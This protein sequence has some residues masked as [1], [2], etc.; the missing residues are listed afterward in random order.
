M[1]RAR[2]SVANGVGGTSRILQSGWNAVKC[3]GTSL[4]RCSTAHRV[5]ASISSS[6]SFS[7]G[8][9]SV[10]TSSQTF[11]SWARYLR[12]S[13]TGRGGRRT[14]PGRTAP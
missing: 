11:V 13:S 12:V 14:P 3:H 5:I 4:P 9:R 10:V 8:I 2:R 1:A 7:P 6:A